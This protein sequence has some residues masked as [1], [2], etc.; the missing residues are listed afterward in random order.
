MTGRRPALRGPA[1]LIA[2]G[3]A[4]PDRLPVLRAVA[5][6]FAVAVT[7]A[8]ADL[9]DPADPNDPIARQFVPDGRELVIDPAERADPIGDAVHAPVPGIVHRYADR[10]LLKAVSVCPVYCRF[11]FRRETVGPDG[12]GTLTDGELDAALAYISA[13]P[14]VWEVILTGGDP[15]VLSPRRIAD[16]VGRLDAIAHVGVVRVHTR[17]PVVDPDRIDAAMVAALRAAGKPTWIMV[18][19]NH[20]REL[21]GGGAAAL[22]RLADAGFPLLSQSVLLKGVNDDPATLEA[23]FRALVRNRVKPHYLHHGDLAQGTGHFRTT[24][25]EGRA[26]VAGLRGRVSGLCQPTY[27]LDIPGGFG[28]VPAGPTW[29]EQDGADWTVRDPTGQR[30]AYQDR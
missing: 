3:L 14:A 22:A 7:P 20:P 23:L 25:A 18:H 28:K 26:L 13:R 15:L 19:V 24:L 6:R 29:I 4:P 9:I 8:M 11:C 5:A 1:D 21:D 27:V 10:V 2:A 17:V 12:D 30:H 16:I